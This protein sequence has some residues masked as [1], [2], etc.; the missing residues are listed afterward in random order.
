M[1]YLKL[2]RRVR[3]LIVSPSVVMVM[4]PHLAVVQVRTP[5][6]SS[7]WVTFRDGKLW[8]LRL[9][10]DITAIFGFTAASHFGVVAVREPWW[11]T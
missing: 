5:N 10:Q 3:T 2:F 9:E 7:R 6:E 4:A 8:R 1:H 11:P